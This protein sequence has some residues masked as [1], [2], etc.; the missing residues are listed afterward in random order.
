[1]S[2]HTQ[3]ITVRA[4]RLGI[5]LGRKRF[6]IGPGETIVVPAGAAHTLWSAGS[7]DLRFDAT[8]SA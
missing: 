8:V 7:D 6:V 4:G 3:R 5:E 2:Q 1:M